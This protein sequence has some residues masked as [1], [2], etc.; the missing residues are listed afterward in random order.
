MILFVSENDWA[1]LSYVFQKSL[2]KAGIE[3]RAITLNRHMFDYPEQAE[4]IRDTPTF[5]KLVSDAS[6][7][8]WMHS[9]PLDIPGGYVSIQNKKKKVVFHGGSAY[10]NNPDELNKIFNFCDLTLFQNYDLKALDTRTDVHT[11]MIMPAVD[12]ELIKPAFSCHRKRVVAHFPR[13]HQKGTQDINEVLA[14]FQ[15]VF[16]YRHIPGQIPVS[17]SDN[18]KRLAECDIYVA[19]LPYDGCTGLGLTL[20]EAAALGKIVINPFEYV[21]EY[22]EDFG[23]YPLLIAND[24]DELRDRLNELSVMSDAELSELQGRIREW[25]ESQHSYKAVGDRLARMLS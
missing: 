25:V 12:T 5:F 4:I 3:A 16:E 13:G 8:V 11:E 20:F 1:N 24:K 22:Q 9:Q 14:E 6:C 10:R 18:M 23:E 7:I 19:S 2:E 21:K 15:G 17:W